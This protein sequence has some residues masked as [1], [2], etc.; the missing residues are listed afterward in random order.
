[1]QHLPPH[2]VNVGVCFTGTQGSCLTVCLHALDLP[3]CKRLHIAG[4]TRK[5]PGVRSLPQRAM[6]AWAMSDLVVEPESVPLVIMIWDFCL[7]LWRRCYVCCFCDS[8]NGYSTSMLTVRLHVIG[9]PVLAELCEAVP[10]P[11]C[12]RLSDSLTHGTTT[13]QKHPFITTAFT[14]QTSPCFPSSLANCVQGV[15]SWKCSVGLAF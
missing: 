3:A 15:K 12:L 5:G 11:A 1:M 9:N 14:S 4:L 6:S 10:S 2:L 8:L 13:F 7:L